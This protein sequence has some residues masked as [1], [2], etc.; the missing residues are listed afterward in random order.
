MTTLVLATNRPKAAQ[1]FLRA[2]KDIASWDEIILIHDA[3]EP[4]SGTFSEKVVQFCWKDIPDELNDIISRQDSAIKSFGFYKAVEL[5][6]EYVH[7]LD[8]DCLPIDA[9]DIADEH[10]NNLRGLV[11]VWESSVSGM[12]VRGL[13]YESTVR[14]RHD[15]RVSLGLW[16]GIPD[17]DAIQTF[18]GPIQDFVPPDEVRVVAK[19]SQVPFCGM[20]FAFHKSVLTGMYFPLMGQG[21]PF[22]RWDDIW[23]GV[24]LKKVLDNLGL[25]MT[26]GK[27]HVYHSRMSNKYVNL[28]K[29]SGS[30]SAHE[31]L[32]EIVHNAPSADTIEG[33][34]YNIAN[35]LIHH[36]SSFPLSQFREYVQRYGECLERW[37]QAVSKLK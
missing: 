20:N 30:I 12:R 8:D 5:G 13:P 19:G 24:V 22:G 33:S 21:Q 32:W 7:V 28:M 29:E 31:Y 17:L 34:V 26:V 6:A 10:N 9:S 11:P 27:P 35:D 1:E 3:P 23:G 15:V 16:H 18:R 14:V 2:W 36:G 4:M 37:V 25:V